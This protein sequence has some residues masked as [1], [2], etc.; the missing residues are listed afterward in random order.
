MGFY[1][2]LSVELVRRPVGA[3][4]GE[5]EIKHQMDP[6]WSHIDTHVTSHGPVSQREVKNQLHGRF[7][8]NLMFFRVL[9]PKVM[10]I[11][12]HHVQ[13]F[14]QNMRSLLQ[15]TMYHCSAIPQLPL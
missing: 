6:V 11:S 10:S 7:L 14:L 15:L 12:L 13:C 5:S 1:F 2:F 8:A 9:N 3:D 4:R